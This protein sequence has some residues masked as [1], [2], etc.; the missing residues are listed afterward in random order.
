MR[1]GLDP[2]PSSKKKSKG[3]VRKQMMKRE[4]KKLGK[5]IETT[6]RILYEKYYETQDLQSS[7]VRLVST[8]LDVLIVRHQRLTAAIDDQSL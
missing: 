6:R 2:G 7:A 4:L 5:E 3:W 8:T 1:I